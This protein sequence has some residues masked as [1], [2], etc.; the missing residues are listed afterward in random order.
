[1]AALSYHFR[2]DRGA[3]EHGGTDPDRFALADHENLVE[4]D[5]SAYISRYLFY[6][7]FF[8]GSDAILLAAG[9]YDRIH[10]GDSNGMTQRTA[11]YTDRPA[12]GQWVFGVGFGA[13]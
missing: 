5:F 4:S 13:W 11:Q 8:A 9:F 12:R 7:E 6:F 3:G 1:M 10:D 2:G